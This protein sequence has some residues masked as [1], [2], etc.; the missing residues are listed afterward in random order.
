MIPAPVLQGSE[1]VFLAPKKEK[2]EERDLCL[3]F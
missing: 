1:D 3:Y 2:P